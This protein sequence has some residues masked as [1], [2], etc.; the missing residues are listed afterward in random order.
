MSDTNEPKS[1]V[2]ESQKRAN[3]KWAEKN[4]TKNTYIK[5]RSS[6]R[7]FIRNHASEDDIEEFRTLLDERLT[8]LA[9]L[10]REEPQENN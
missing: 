1:K 6:A 10:K 2:S 4:K 9:E 7:S 3:K 5:T 8:L